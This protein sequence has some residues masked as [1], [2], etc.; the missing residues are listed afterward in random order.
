MKTDRFRVEGGRSTENVEVVVGIFVS[1]LIEFDE[2]VEFEVQG[3]SI[4][5]VFLEDGCD[6]RRVVEIV[7]ETIALQSFLLVGYDLRLRKDVDLADFNQII[8]FLALR[9]HKRHECAELERPVIDFDFHHSVLQNM[10]HRTLRDDATTHCQVTHSSSQFAY[11][12]YH[13]SARIH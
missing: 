9:T 1:D 7:F 2:L 4:G 13:L 5:G 11:W 12:C 8:E 3:D 10:P 6:V